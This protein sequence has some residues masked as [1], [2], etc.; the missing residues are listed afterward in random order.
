MAKQKFLSDVVSASDLTL[1]KSVQPKYPQKAELNKVQGW[2]E[3]DFTVAATGE[4]M[5]IA[6]H[7]ANAPGVFEEAAISAL[8][9]WR[10]QPMLRDAK[11][12]PQR[13]RI[14]I[15]FSLAP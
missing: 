3:L 4:V 8:S 12:V 14:R 13:V 5:D 9:Q 11:P 15:R 1:L 7:A 10:Y 6:V 2:V